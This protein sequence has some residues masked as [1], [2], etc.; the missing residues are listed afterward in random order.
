MPVWGIVYGV[1]A[2]ARSFVADYGSLAQLVICAP[3]GICAGLAFVM[4]YPPSCQ[5]AF[6]VVRALREFR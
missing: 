2:L 5:T 4:V 1:T 6:T 3:F